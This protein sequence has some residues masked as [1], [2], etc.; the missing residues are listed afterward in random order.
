M[1][2]TERV[3]AASRGAVTKSSRSVRSES[4]TETGLYYYRARYYDPTIGRFL[5]ED[6]I[7]FYG[8]QDSYIYARNHTIDHIDPLGL[9]DFKY[10]LTYRG[11]S[12]GSARLFDGKFYPTLPPSIR[13]DCKGLGNGQYKL[14]INVTWDILI[15]YFSPE[16]LLHEEGHLT[17]GGAGQRKL[18]RRVDWALSSRFT[19]GFG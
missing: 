16:Q 13:A 18:D 3:S 9:T 12:N 5:N 17:A 1:D 10:N 6:P 8:A 14:T 11:S 2:Y 15:V 4:D 19:P 7:G